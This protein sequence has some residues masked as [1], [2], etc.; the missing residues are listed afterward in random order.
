M[1]A[2]IFHIISF[3]LLSTWPNFCIFYFDFF[4]KFNKQLFLAKVRS[5]SHLFAQSSLLCRKCIFRECKRPCTESIRMCEI[6]SNDT[7]AS[8]FPVLVVVHDAVFRKKK[9]TLL[10]V[11]IDKKYPAGLLH[12]RFLMLPLITQLHQG[13]N[14]TIAF[15]SFYHANFSFVHRH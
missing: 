3:L 8:S 10:I 12:E 15:G 9:R 13:T 11:Q 4:Q 6:Y 2:C 14:Q 7:E 5:V 1:Y